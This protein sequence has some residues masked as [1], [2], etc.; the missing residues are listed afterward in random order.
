KKQ[1]AFNVVFDKQAM[2]FRAGWSGQF[3]N[4]SDR[5]FGL[6]EK[7]TIGGD[8]AWRVTPDSVWRILPSEAD[9]APDQKPQPA[10]E[11]VYNGLTLDGNRVIL[12]YSVAGCAI[13]ESPTV[14]QDGPRTAVVREIE[15]GPSTHRLQLPIVQW[16][17]ATI[18][19]DGN[20][21]EK[22]DE[23][24]LVRLT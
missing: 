11:L 8:I 6:L 22:G 10:G 9:A 14:S 20:W 17:D 5:R 7:P 18:S 4:F 13:L 15:C 1:P 24:L 21:L 19:A 12:S 23:A 3:L 2:M 16:A